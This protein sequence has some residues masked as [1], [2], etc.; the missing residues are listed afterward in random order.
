MVAFLPA[1]HSLR[2]R[3][4]NDTPGVCELETNGHANT[5]DGEDI[6]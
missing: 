4:A 6:L 1:G 5:V 3:S 2:A